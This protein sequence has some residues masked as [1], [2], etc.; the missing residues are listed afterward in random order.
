MQLKDKE[1]KLEKGNIP[2]DW[3]ESP[4]DV[5]Y[6]DIRE[7]IFL[8]HI[9]KQKV[10]SK[11]NSEGTEWSVDFKKGDYTLSWDKTPPLY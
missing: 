4:Y 5:N 6:E 10:Y 7:R 1:I 8:L 9:S 2:T 3:N 11:A